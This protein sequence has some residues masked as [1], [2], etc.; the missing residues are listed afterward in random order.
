MSF[1]V[2]FPGPSGGLWGASWEPVEG[3]LGAFWALLGLLGAS[4]AHLG[5]PGGLLRLSWAPFWASWEPLGALLGLSRVLLGLSWGAPG[6][7]L[8]VILASRECFSE[9]SGALRTDF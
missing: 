5:S 3:L 4:W 9:A 1:F 6:A 8:G 2:R 7:L